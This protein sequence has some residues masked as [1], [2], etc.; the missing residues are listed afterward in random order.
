MKAFAGNK[1]LYYSRT[2]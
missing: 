1:S 2:F